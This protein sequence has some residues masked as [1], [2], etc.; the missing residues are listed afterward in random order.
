MNKPAA[1]PPV[2]RRTLG[3]FTK[4]LAFYFRRNFH[5]THLLRLF[6]LDQLE[7]WPLL[8]CM[9]HPSWWDP[10]L[11]V[12]LSQ[13]FFKSRKQYGPIA[14]AGLAKYRFFERLGFFG[15]DPATSAGAHR[16]L[17]IGQAVLSRDDGAIWMTPQGHFTDVRDRPVRLQAGVGHLA[18]SVRRF[19]MLPLAVEYCYWNERYPEAFACFGTPIFVENGFELPAREWTS[20]FAAALESTQDTLSERVRQRDPAAFELLLQGSSGAGGVY[21]LWRSV[22]ARVRGR[23]FEPEHG[24][25]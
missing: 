17:E 12:Y 16:F 9:N 3:W 25:I 6:P 22:K 20:K 21:D 14:S 15:I 4:Y 10:L 1:L 8:V 7:G 23:K 11:G 18:R 24:R 2:A 5:G 19:A 13:R